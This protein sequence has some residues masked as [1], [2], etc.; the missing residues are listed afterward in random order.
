MAEQNLKKVLQGL[1]DKSSKALLKVIT[2]SLPEGVSLEDPKSLENLKT[3]D[4]KNIIKAVD[5]VVKISDK[6]ASDKGKTPE[7]AKN[8][9]D[10][11]RKKH[12]DT[13]KKW[14][15]FY[16]K[17]S[18]QKSNQKSNLS[19]KD[20]QGGLKLVQSIPP[21]KIEKADQAMSNELESA[22]R[23]DPEAFNSKVVKQDLG[24]ALLGGALGVGSYFAFKKGGG[25][26]NA[27]T[28][29]GA[30]LFLGALAV[31]AIGLS[32]VSKK[33][34]AA[35]RAFDA[36]KAKPDGKRDDK[37]LMRMYKSGMVKSDDDMDAKLD[38]ED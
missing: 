27:T 22:F 33:E 4:L 32:S 16:E 21:K 38:T 29:A 6:K 10:A 19:D 7:A 25:K 31:S 35:Q 14:Q 15:D 36:E 3:K 23:N 34:Q 1:D 8:I 11:Y 30:G 26:M 28:G 5:S 2:N 37:L 12:P 24:A 20:I 17:D 9:F 13:N 18:N